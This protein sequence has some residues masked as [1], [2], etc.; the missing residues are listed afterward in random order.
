MKCRAPQSEGLA[1]RAARAR[2]AMSAAT[3]HIVGVWSQMLPDIAPLRMIISRTDVAD[4]VM[5]AYVDHAKHVAGI[6]LSKHML[7]CKVGPLVWR[8]DRAFA[9]VLRFND[10]WTLGIEIMFT[11]MP[12]LPPVQD[13]ELGHAVDL[14]PASNSEPIEED[15]RRIGQLAPREP[16]LVDGEWHICQ[17]VSALIHDD[18]IWCLLSKML[19]NEVGQA[20]SH[21]QAESTRVRQSWRALVMLFDRLA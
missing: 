13:T 21:T 1:P 15:A 10:R 19:L 17:S 2:I 3:S 5:C 20:T 6:S 12:H 11:Q 14:S 9:T 8:W 16:A 7:E 18:P 4:I